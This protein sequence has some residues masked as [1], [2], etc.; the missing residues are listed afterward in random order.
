MGLLSSEGPGNVSVPG[1]PGF[2]APY[3]DLF[4]PRGEA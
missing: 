4:P 3:R 1:F 2:H